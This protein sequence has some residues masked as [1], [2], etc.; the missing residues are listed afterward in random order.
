MKFFK[1]NNDKGKEIPTLPT[2]YSGVEACENGFETIQAGVYPFY[3]LSLLIHQLVIEPFP[4]AFPS[5]SGIWIHIGNN[6]VAIKGTAELLSIKSGIKV[7]EEAVHGNVYI[8]GLL[9]ELSD[10]LLY[11]IEI[12]MVPA[13]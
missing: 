7:T 2:E 10:S 9:Y 12:S 13:L 8:G 1:E 3:F 5:V 4:G 6:A 11:L